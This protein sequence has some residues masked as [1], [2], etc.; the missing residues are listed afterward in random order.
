METKKTLAVFFCCNLVFHYSAFGG[1][2]SSDLIITGVVDGPLSDGTPK[3]VELYAV[4]AIA[5][6]SI[7]G[8]GSANNGNG[9]DG[10]EYTFP[11]DSISAGQFIYVASDTV[12]FNAFFG[13]DADYT[14]G[15]ALING[16]DAVELFM[17]GSV[18]DVFGDINVDG[19]GQPWEHLDGWAYRVSDTGPEA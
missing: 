16:D 3:A 11:A 5:D 17:N 10:E 4:D 8:I 6:L 14:D 1:P 13:F 9:T 2:P 19:T 15:A 12:P 7:Y 18:V